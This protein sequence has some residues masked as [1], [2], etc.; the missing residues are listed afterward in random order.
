MVKDQCRLDI[1]KYSFK[2]RKINVW[3]KLSTCCVTA[4]KFINNVE[5]YLRRADYYKDDKM[6]DSR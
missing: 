3:C 5:A 2:R 1:R 6:L 4:N